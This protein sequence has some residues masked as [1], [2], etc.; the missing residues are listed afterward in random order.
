MPAITTC[1]SQ[2]KA[3]RFPK[4]TKA[5]VTRNRLARREGAPGGALLKRPRAPGGYWA[6]TVLFLIDF[7][8]WAWGIVCGID[9]G[10]G[11]ALT[12]TTLNG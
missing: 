4:P 7:G 12:S 3:S 10:R 5:D 2:S 11:L 1:R 9:L 8:G 6:G